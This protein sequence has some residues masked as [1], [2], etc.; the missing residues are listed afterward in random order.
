MREPADPVTGGVIGDAAAA[1]CPA[2]H[3]HHRDPCEPP[4]GTCHAAAESAVRAA[5]PRLLTNLGHTQSDKDP[6]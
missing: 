1:I 5:L 2:T 3:R 6:E 4:C